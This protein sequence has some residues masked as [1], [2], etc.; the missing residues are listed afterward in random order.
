MTGLPEFQLVPLERL[1]THERVDPRKVGEL[2]GE[3]ERTGLFSEPIWVAR[4]SWVIL[5][6]HHRAEA[7]RRLGAKRVPSWVFDY[8]SDA[9]ELRRWTPGPP[10]PKAEVVRRAAQGEPFPPKT[11]RHRITIELPARVV[12]LEDLLD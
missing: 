7:L 11:T 2:V 10:I 12:R 1:R 8:E 9:V 5:N 3:L 4:G 6:G